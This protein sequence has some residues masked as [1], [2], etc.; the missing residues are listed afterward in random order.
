M[1]LWRGALFAGACHMIPAVLPG[2][3]A[4]FMWDAMM[5]GSLDFRDE[6]EVAEFLSDYER[7]ESFR[8]WYTHVP[9]LILVCLAV[10]GAFQH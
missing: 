7:V 1:W 6:A 4:A 8:S 5:N 2:K 9:S 10:T 3:A